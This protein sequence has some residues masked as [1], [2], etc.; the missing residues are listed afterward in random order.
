M[1]TLTGTTKTTTHDIEVK[2]LTG[3]TEA[4][5]N[6]IE[7]NENIDRYNENNTK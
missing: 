3:T 7:V 1:K 4:T 2:S 5:T 6:D